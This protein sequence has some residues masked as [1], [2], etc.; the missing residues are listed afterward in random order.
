MKCSTGNTL[1]FTLL[2]VLVLMHPVDAAEPAPTLQITL[3]PSTV[4]PNQP[5]TFSWTSTNATECFGASA[6]PQPPTGSIDG[7]TQIKTHRY[8]MTCYGLGGVVTKYQTLTVVPPAPVFHEWGVKTDA[9]AAPKTTVTVAAGAPLSLRWRVSNA[10]YC[11]GTSGKER[12]IEEEVPFSVAASTRHV[13]TCHNALGGVTTRT[14][15]VYVTG[16]ESWPTIAHWLSPQTVAKGGSVKRQWAPQSTA[17]GCRLNHDWAMLDNAPGSMTTAPI[18]KGTT[19]ATQ[20]F[21]AGGA[22]YSNHASVTIERKM[23]SVSVSP[24]SATISA[25]QSANFTWSA[26]PSNVT[27]TGIGG[28]PLSGSGGVFATGPLSRTTTFAFACETEGGHFYEHATVTVLQ[29]TPAWINLGLCD[30]RT[31][32]Q[33]QVCVDG[34]ACALNSLRVVEGNCPQQVDCETP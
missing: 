19:F 23:P 13:L 11:Y 14:A 3:S 25:G 24:K 31:N 6:R 21:T 33:Q 9:N 15:N 4:E 10:D 27:C 8:A 32:T 26:T 7:I 29:A 30:P 2:S 5:F 1:T 17:V 28:A 22:S 20:C 16:S 12:L 34:D 18:H